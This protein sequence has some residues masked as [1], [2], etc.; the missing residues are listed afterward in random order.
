MR[1]DPGGD[2][3]GFSFHATFSELGR[4]RPSPCGSLRTWQHFGGPQCFVGDVPGRSL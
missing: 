3:R 1:N 2:R 4:G